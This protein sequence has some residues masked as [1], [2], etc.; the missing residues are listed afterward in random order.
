MTIEDESFRNEKDKEPAVDVE[1]A[2]E[3]NTGDLDKGNIFQSHLVE[4]FFVSECME[5]GLVWNNINMKLLGK[6]G[7]QTKLDILKGVWGGAEAGKTTAIMGASGA[8]KTSL[9]STLA[10]RVSTK[11]KIVVEGDIYLGGVKIDPCDQENRRLFAYVSQEESLDE[12]STPR[13][14]LEFS[15]RLRLPKTLPNEEIKNTV[16]ACL[17]EL[18]LESVA[19]NVIGGGLK[20]GLSGGERRRVSIGVELV[21]SPSIIFLDEP[22]SGLDSYAAM[23]VMTLLEKVAKAG[24]I[25]LFTI[26][27]PSSSLFSQFDRLILLKKGRVM[28]QGDVSKVGEEFSRLGYPVP[29][30]YNPADWIIDLAQTKSIKELE[31]SGFFPGEPAEHLSMINPDEK[32]NFPDCNHVSMWREF[33]FLHQRE[34][35]KIKR[36]PMSIIINVCLT[37]VL[38][39]IFGVIF[40]DIGRQDRSNYAV[41]T[42]IASEGF[43]T[44]FRTLTAILSFLNFGLGHSISSWC[45]RKPLDMHAHGPVKY[46]T[47]HLQQG[48]SSFFERILHWSLLDLSLFSFEIMERGNQFLGCNTCTNSCCVLVDGVSNVV[49]AV[50]CCQLRISFDSHSSCSNDWCIHHR[51]QSRLK[52]LHS[53]GCSSVLLFR[54]VYCD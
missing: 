14:A 49:L 53:C 6:K 41:R 34:M 47:S 30:N 9:F 48:P 42:P 15:A 11:G 25:V 31:A 23:Q 39:A 38:S 44:A 1:E 36:N 35:R 24:N 7:G 8:G 46:R 29:A 50:A 33:V 18:G 43:D 22:T 52:F 37:S 5:K 40:F 16:N 51:S 2:I 19:D 32:L 21:A 26:H 45:D 13:E 10:G 3:K 4:S 54:P 17:E 28:H 12:T 27:Q 20:K